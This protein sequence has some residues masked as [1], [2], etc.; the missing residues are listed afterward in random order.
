MK[1][2][3]IKKSNESVFVSFIYSTQLPVIED[4]FSI[5][6]ALSLSRNVTL[7]SD[8]TKLGHC[9]LHCIVD[10]RSDVLSN[11]ARRCFR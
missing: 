3:R 5:F 8:I 7:S 6:Q 11:A 9:M 1:W 2:I 10:N 4:V